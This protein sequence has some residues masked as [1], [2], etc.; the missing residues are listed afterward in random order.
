M[1]GI[2][3]IYGDSLTNKLPEWPS[4][5]MSRPDDHS[6]VV[7]AAHDAMRL[8]IRNEST[9]SYQ[10]LKSELHGIMPALD[11]ISDFYNEEQDI[12]NVKIPSFIQRIS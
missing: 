6:E 3:S 10:S 7:S 12:G 9:P 1:K 11:A 8:I 4:I 2:A 5:S